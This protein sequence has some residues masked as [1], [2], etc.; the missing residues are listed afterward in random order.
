MPQRLI[1]LDTETTG[2]DDKAEIL[3]L[4]II[5]GTG[6]TIIDQYF[7]P[8]HTVQQSTTSSLHSIIS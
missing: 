8:E 7:R 3:Q 4:S 6:R 1:S 2:I 5:D